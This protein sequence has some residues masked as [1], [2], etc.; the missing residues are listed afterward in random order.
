[1]RNS[2]ILTRNTKFG[3]NPVQLKRLSLLIL[4]FLFVLILN[5]CDMSGTTKIDPPKVPNLEAG[6]WN[7]LAG[8]GETKCANGT[9]YTYYAHKG[10]QNKL[11][12]DFQGGG[13]CWDS[14]TCAFPITQGQGFYVNKVNGSPTD[15]GY[16]GIYNRANDANP[17]KDW[18]HVFA[19]YCTGDI[20]LGN[21]DAEYINPFDPTQTYPIFHRG[22]VNVK[23]VLD[24]TFENFEK[25]EDIFVTGCSAGAYGAAAWIETIRKH[26]GDDVS[27]TQLGDCGAG[28]ST[29]AF[30]SVIGSA[31][32]IANVAE[33]GVTELT[34]TF[35]EN[36][37]IRVANDYPDVQLAQYNTTRDSVQVGFYSLGKGIFEPTET[38]IDEW[39][40]GLKASMSKI[41]TA[42]SN[43]ASYTAEH[44]ADPT[45]TL[46]QHCVISRPD[47]Y[48]ITEN[49]S[50]LLTWITDLVNGKPVSS[51][52][53]SVQVSIP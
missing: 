34:S 40:D 38:E 48:T 32:G 29:P 52:A 20:H 6:K 39:S 30:S 50:S 9:D 53:P 42:T 2:G 36:T 43:F 13:A 8:G 41:H 22:A 35:T 14:Q 4:T 1:M 17:V 33:L 11:V 45:S 49:G 7:E 47:M 37:Y 12:I 31:W 26:Y 21:K 51:V 27:I 10:D 3:G 46:T 18:Y 25:P 24:W 28:I 15:I 5:S 16:D 44:E 23:A 19:P